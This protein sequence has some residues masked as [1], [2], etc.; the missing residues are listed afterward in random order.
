MPSAKLIA[1]KLFEERGV[2]GWSEENQLEELR[3]KVYLKGRN[4]N[5]PT[6]YLAPGLQYPMY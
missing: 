1:E 6:V 4:L 2:L 3:G 5:T